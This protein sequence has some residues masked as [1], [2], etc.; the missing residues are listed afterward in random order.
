MERALDPGGGPGAPVNAIAAIRGFP[1]AGFQ[2]SGGSV[3]L[4]DVFI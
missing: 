4:G 1:F 2:H 3:V